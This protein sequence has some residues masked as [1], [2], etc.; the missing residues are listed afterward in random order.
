M[1]DLGHD[2]FDQ[3]APP[4]A[5]APPLQQGDKGAC[6]EA[7]E[8]RRPVGRPACP[9]PFLVSDSDQ[10]FIQAFRTCSSSVRISDLVGIRTFWRFVSGRRRL[11]RSAVRSRMWRPSRPAGLGGTGFEL[12]AKRVA[13]GVKA[14]MV[15]DRCRTGDSLPAERSDE[16]IRNLQCERPSALRLRPGADSTEHAVGV[17]VLHR[18]SRP[19]CPCGNGLKPWVS[20]ARSLGTCETVRP[21]VRPWSAPSSEFGCG[22]TDQPAVDPPG[23][24]ERE[25]PVESANPKGHSSSARRIASR[26]LIVS[27]TNPLWLS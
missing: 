2:D 1:G 3:D 23:V 5:R 21:P 18:P 16:Q 26:S 6:S 15:L 27:D 17:R 11:G 8:G 13:R 22:V 25:D 19:L 12:R 4:G 24:L 7:R 10:G 20:R 9:A 14:Q